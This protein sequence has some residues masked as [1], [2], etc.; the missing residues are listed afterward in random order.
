MEAYT[1]G[2]DFRVVG[3]LKKTEAIMNQTFWIG[4]YPG[5]TQKHLV[6]SQ[7]SLNFARSFDKSK[8][9]ALIFV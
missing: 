6:I 5:M 4:V 8:V 7:K 3:E 9:R 1:A 2:K